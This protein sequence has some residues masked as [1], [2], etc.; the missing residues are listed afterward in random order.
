MDEVEKKAKKNKEIIG[1]QNKVS[2][3]LI[4]PSLFT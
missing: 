3:T 4:L 2:K 1:R